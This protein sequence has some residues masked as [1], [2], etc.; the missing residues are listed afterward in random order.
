MSWYSS[1]STQ[2]NSWRTASP[3][4]GIGQQGVPVEQ[5]VVV[6]EHAGRFL[7]VDVAVEQL[8]QLLVP[9]LAPGE[10]VRAARRRVFRGR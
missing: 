6:V 5:Q 3:A 7:A 2:S 10:M 8:L 9:I 1:T 4:F